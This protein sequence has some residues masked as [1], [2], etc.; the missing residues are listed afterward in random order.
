MFIKVTANSKLNSVDFKLGSLRMAPLVK[1]P[2]M[3]FRLARLIFTCIL[4]Y[5]LNYR[6]GIQFEE[7]RPRS[8][9]RLL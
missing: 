7:D 3:V 2:F 9:V 6:L 1:I 5:Y 4:R 8:D